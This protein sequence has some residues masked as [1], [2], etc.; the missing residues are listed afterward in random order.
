[1][2]TP[3]FEYSAYEYPQAWSRDWTPRIPAV[4]DNDATTQPAPVVK[5]ARSGLSI[6]TIASIILCILAVLIAGV[7]LTAVLTYTP[8][9]PSWVYDTHTGTYQYYPHE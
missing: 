3:I 7:G 6:T 1:M 9:S 4:V 8:S 2:S 5:L